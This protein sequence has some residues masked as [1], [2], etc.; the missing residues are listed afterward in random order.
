MRDCD[1]RRVTQTA[2]SERV[3]LKALQTEEGLM[4]HLAYPI[5]MQRKFALALVI[6]AAGS[7]TLGCKAGVKP[8]PTPGTGGSGNGPG[9]GG[10]TGAAGSNG[11][12]GFGGFGGSISINPDAGACQQKD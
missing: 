8:T 11:G 2:A 12:P 6:L 4:A 5:A 10:T 3:N 7:M 1:R 9:T